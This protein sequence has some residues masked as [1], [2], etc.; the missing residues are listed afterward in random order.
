MLEPRYIGERSPFDG[1]QPWRM[2]DVVRQTR[3]STHTSRQQRSNR[4]GGNVENV[5]RHI[6]RHV[7]YF[8]LQLHERIE[9]TRS[10]E[11]GVSPWLHETQGPEL[12]RRASG[13]RRQ[14]AD[15]AKMLRSVRVQ[16]SGSLCDA[17]RTGEEPVPIVEHP[18]GQ[19]PGP[20][21]QAASD[22]A[23]ERVSRL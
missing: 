16:V 19:R 7:R 13:G 10:F 4:C 22:L 1:F 15:F 2:C 5:A 6:D 23:D 20:P 12:S 14:S 17:F 11:A 18:R 3:G 21:K 8:A 9:Q